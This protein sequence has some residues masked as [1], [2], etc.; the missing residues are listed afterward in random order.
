ME[1]LRKHKQ[2]KDEDSAG[3]VYFHWFCTSVFPNINLMSSQRAIFNWL[4]ER[5]TIKLTLF[6]NHNNNK[7]NKFS[8]TKFSKPTNY[9][10]K[11]K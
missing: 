2:P 8:F 6:K 4:R 9:N 1:I 11:F 3:R 10:P 7:N 5:K